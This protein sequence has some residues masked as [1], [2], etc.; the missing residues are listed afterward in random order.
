M[1]I[2]KKDGQKAS[3]RSKTTLLLRK[4]PYS[5]SDG[6][7]ET[8]LETDLVTIQEGKIIQIQNFLGC[9]DNN[10]RYGGED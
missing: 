1:D 2:I 4:S 6:Q 10:H 8:V 5:L 7:T 3:A 9:N